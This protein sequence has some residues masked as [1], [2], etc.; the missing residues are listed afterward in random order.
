MNLDWLPQF[1][2]SFLVIT[3]VFNVALGACA[4]L[5]FL[6]RKM[7]SWIQDRIGPNRTNLGFGFLP[8]KIHMMGFGQALADGLK[9]LLKEDFTP[10]RVDKWLFWL[11]PAMVMLTATLSWAVI[12]WAGL[13]AI[14]EIDWFGWGTSAKQIVFGTAAP[15]NIGVV[16][17][18]AVSS[19]AVYGVVVGS[20]A[21]N[22]K[23]SFLGGVRAA[24]QMLSYEIPQ[25]ICVLVMIMMFQATMTTDIAAAQI[26]EN[27][28]FGLD[29]TGNTWGIFM[30]PLLAILFFVCTL[31]EC[32]RA[33]FDLA[34]AEQEL[35]GG[36]HTEYGSMK[37]A[38]FFL[39]EYM[40]MITASAFFALLFLGGWD[41][42]PF[43]KVLPDYVADNW[44]LG[45][46]LAFVKFGVFAGKVFVIIAVMMWV[47]WTLPRLRFD[48]LMRMAWRGMIPLTIATMLVTSFMLYFGFRNWWWY[49]IMNIVMAVIAALAG[50]YLPKD[51]SN[52]RLPLK[53]SRFSPLPE[54]S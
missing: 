51:T 8:E 15:V 35:V 52:E 31:A 36:F 49:G 3:V 4:Y 11:A 46:L 32:N 50:M 13:I 40:N 10:N 21:S 44:M 28:V 7:A 14:P 9:L 33:P 42:L 47:R 41:V 22:N 45:V 29:L 18:L 1:I 6:E 5:I 17:I 38:L 54:A 2:V 53:G 39:G 24:A 43:F 16:Y 30:H 19:L 34:E 23:Y 48:Q 27:G 26:G 25:G 12:P 20:Y 37:W